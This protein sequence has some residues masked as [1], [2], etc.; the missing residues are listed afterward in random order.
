M[1][2][3]DLVVLA[4]VVLAAVIGFRLGFVTRVLSWIGMLVGI[5]L[6]LL[7]LGPLLDGVDPSEPAA[8]AW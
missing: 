7:V 8:R 6:A 4:G 3:V 2:W 1:N 5:V